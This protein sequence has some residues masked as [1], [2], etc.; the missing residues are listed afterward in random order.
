MDVQTHPVRV[1]RS[2]RSNGTKAGSS[3]LKYILAIEFVENLRRPGQGG[4]G[5]S[6]LGLGNSPEGAVKICTI[7]KQILWVQMTIDTRLEMINLKRAYDP[8][9]STDGT[10]FLVER[11]WPRGVKKT[12]LHVHAWLKDVAPSTTLRRWF[13]H[14]PKKWSEFRRRYFHELR[15]HAEVLDPILKL[16]R[17]SR[18][19]LVYSS[20]D[21]EHNNAVALKDYLEARLGKKRVPHE[22]AT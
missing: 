5:E 22:A 13:G 17:R 18:V 7:D 14:D 8:V 4:L 11:L 2:S 16:A 19:T 9:A 12:A 20:H 3:K 10:R 6:P 1:V 15:A 21:M